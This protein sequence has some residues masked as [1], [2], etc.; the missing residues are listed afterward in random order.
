[1]SQIRFTCQSLVGTDK[2]GIIPMD[3]NG[4]YDMVIGGMNILNS[5][6]QYYDYQSA[7]S[8]FENSSS[9]MRRVQRGAL[10]GECGHPRQFPGQS[11]DSYM[12][13]ILDI[14]ESNVCV[15]YSEVYLDFDHFKNPDGSAVV[16]IRAKLRP[17][18]PKA[19]FL[20]DAID[21]PKE[22]VC[23]SIRSFTENNYYKGRINKTLKTIVTF[24]YV[25]EPGIHIAEKYKAPNLESLVDLAVSQEQLTVVFECRQTLH[26]GNESAILTKQELFDAFGWVE[27]PQSRLRQW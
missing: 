2:K 3:A 4:Y 24:D 20:K 6:G 11:M 14:D 21:N 22:N 13:R 27:K 12:S 7:K 16:A 26:L 18:G 15:H 9:F 5:A 19:Q 10:R 23:F 8:L 1:M 17:S 25:N